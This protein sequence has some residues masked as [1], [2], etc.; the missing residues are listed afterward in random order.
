[1]VETWEFVFQPDGDMWSVCVRGFENLAEHPFG[2][3]YT[4]R[5]ALEELLSRMPE[6]TEPEYTKPE[7]EKKLETARSFMRDL[8]EV[9]DEYKGAFD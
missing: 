2:F 7:L 9:F 1:M 4:K 3:G 8:Q 6:F 5:E